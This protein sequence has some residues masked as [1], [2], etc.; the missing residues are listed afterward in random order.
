MAD[1]GRVLGGSRVVLD[2][3]VRN[4]ALEARI[5]QLYSHLLES[6]RVIRRHEILV[7]RTIKPHVLLI[8]SLS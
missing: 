8:N 1:S 7:L 6:V 5:T 3:L 4:C 2:S